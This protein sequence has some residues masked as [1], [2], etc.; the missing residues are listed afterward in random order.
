VLEAAKEA[1]VA[2]LQVACLV[3]AVLT[4][5]AAVVAWRLIPAEGKNVR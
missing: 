1:F 4:A 5:L 3:A 2:S